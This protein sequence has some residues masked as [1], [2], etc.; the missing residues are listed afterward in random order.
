MGGFIEPAVT[1]FCSLDELRKMLT[2]DEPAWRS[3][4][5]REAAEEAVLRFYEDG[6]ILPDGWTN[7]Y[8]DFLCILDG[9]KFE[10]MG[11]YA[12]M[13]RNPISPDEVVAFYSTVDD[14]DEWSDDA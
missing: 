8:E 1:E 9:E 7:N 11:P 3:D 10:P 13:N 14:D 5:E 4:A 12:H 2:E 6:W